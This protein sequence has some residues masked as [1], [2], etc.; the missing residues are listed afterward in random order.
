MEDCLPNQYLETK[1]AVISGHVA[2]GPLSPDAI[3]GPSSPDAHY[4]D[5]AADFVSHDAADCPKCQADSFMRDIRS[6]G[7]WG[8]CGWVEFSWDVSRT[9]RISGGV[10][11]RTAC[12]TNLLCRFSGFPTYLPRFL[13]F[14]LPFRNLPCT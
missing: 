1:A 4:S 8:S 11:D 3:S 5:T 14:T 7:F 12:V 6:F 2:S 9:E 13:H 10:F